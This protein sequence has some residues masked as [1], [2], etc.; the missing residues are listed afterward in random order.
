[1]PVKSVLHDDKNVKNALE[2]HSDL[3][4][5]L[6]KREYALDAFY[7]AIISGE[8]N[9]AIL[10]AQTEIVA[11]STAIN[12]YHALLGILLAKVKEATTDPEYIH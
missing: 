1:M 8:L 6:I 12:A 9:E 4:H 7:T 10:A 5:E 11:A 3:M 2:L